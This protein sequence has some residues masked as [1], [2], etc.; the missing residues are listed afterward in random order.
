ML[1]SSF[2]LPS[3]QPGKSPPLS[4]QMELAQDSFLRIFQKFPEASDKLHPNEAID[5][6]GLHAVKDFLKI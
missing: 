4:F 5:A 6:A 1:F 3:G 2:C